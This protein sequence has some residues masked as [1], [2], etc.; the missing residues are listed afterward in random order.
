MALIQLD[1]LKTPENAMTLA[2]VLYLILY[3]CEKFSSGV[4]RST[5][6]LG[7][8]KAVTQF[9][10]ALI[11]AFVVYEL[12]PDITY[13]DRKLPSQLLIFIPIIVYMLQ[14]YTDT[15]LTSGSEKSN[16]NAKNWMNSMYIFLLLALCM[17]LNWKFYDSQLG[18]RSFVMSGLGIGLYF[19][20]TI[21]ANVSANNSGNTLK[22]FELTDKALNLPKTLTFF[23]TMLYFTVLCMKNVFVSGEAKK[24]KSKLYACAFAIPMIAGAFL[25]GSTVSDSIFGIKRLMVTKL[26]NILKLVDGSWTYHNIC[27]QKLNEIITDIISVKS[28]IN[29]PNANDVEALLTIDDQSVL[30]RFDLTDSVPLDLFQKLQTYLQA[31]NRGLDLKRFLGFYKNTDPLG[32]GSLIAN[33]PGIW[34]CMLLGVVVIAYIGMAVFTKNLSFSSFYPLLGIGSLITFL[35]YLGYTARLISHASSARNEVYCEQYDLK[36]EDCNNSDSQYQQANFQLINQIGIIQAGTGAVTVDGVDVLDIASG[37]NMKTLYNT[38]KNYPGQ[39]AITDSIDT[40]IA[41]FNSLKS[42]AIE[43]NLQAIPDAKSIKMYSAAADPI[44]SDL[45]ITDISLQDLVDV[46]VDSD[47]FMQTLGAKAYVPDTSKTFVSG[48]GNAYFSVSQDPTTKNSV[49]MINYA[50]KGQTFRQHVMD[51][52]RVREIVKEMIYDS[53]NLG[54][55]FAVTMNP[56]LLRNLYSSGEFD[57][58]ATGHPYI[59]AIKTSFKTILS[60]KLSLDL[61][62]DKFA[63]LTSPRTNW[64]SMKAFQTSGQH[65]VIS[66]LPSLTSGDAMTIKDLLMH[67]IAPKADSQYDSTVDAYLGNLLWV[68]KLELLNDTSNVMNE[69]NY[70]ENTMFFGLNV[71][72]GVFVVVFVICLF[73]SLGLKFSSDSYF[74]D[75]FQ[76]AALGSKMSKDH[77]SLFL[78]VT[79]ICLIY[80]VTSFADLYSLEKTSLSNVIFTDTSIWGGKKTTILLVVSICTLLMFVPMYFPSS[81]KREHIYLVTFLL[82]CMMCSPLVYFLKSGAKNNTILVARKFNSVAV[83][84]VFA[85]V[86]LLLISK[87]HPLLKKNSWKKRGIYLTVGMVCLTCVSAPM[88]YLD[89]YQ[90]EI[91]STEFDDRIKKVNIGIYASM[92]IYAALYLLFFVKMQRKQLFA[93]PIPSLWD[94]SSVAIS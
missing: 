37:Q 47:G 90:P 54:N 88:M 77:N 64:N 49:M 58:N 75:Y 27:T 2:F 13:Q 52:F 48:D 83:V 69:V 38:M 41:A 6:V 57:V 42:M 79:L 23:A 15:T 94:R 92:G 59:D 36:G 32:S 5:P 30:D 25:M 74:S 73:S 22:S 44:S 55:N 40:M 86:C 17:I 20:Y 3:V 66:N 4:Q 45:N 11:F 81:E 16:E 33:I 12:G 26:L 43:I 61:T 24:F 65:D 21:Y 82:I 35:I 50:G 18:F 8:L 63:Q 56:Q 78:L 51:L 89:I 76:S 87:D 29:T 14:E 93:N 84:A 7:N 1:G 70:V 80:A 85:C 71:S 9:A 31:R 34:S 67:A 19:A 68:T 10:I 28:S 39:T 91:S 53:A 46:L 72:T 60:S 62:T